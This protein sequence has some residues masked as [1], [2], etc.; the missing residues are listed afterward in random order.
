MFEGM[1]RR[2]SWEGPR[3]QCGR[4]QMVHEEGGR[5]LQ[6]SIQHNYIQHNCIIMWPAPINHPTNNRLE[7]ISVGRNSKR[8][9]LR[10]H[11]PSHSGIC[12]VCAHWH[13]YAWRWWCEA[14]VHTSKPLRKGKHFFTSGHVKAMKDCH[15]GQFDFVKAQ[16]MASYQ[17]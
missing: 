5:L 16:V 17:V 12:A 1:H 7:N 2:K 15:K 4:R 6:A 11:S 13:R 10:T 9:Q 14:D 8:L 3:H